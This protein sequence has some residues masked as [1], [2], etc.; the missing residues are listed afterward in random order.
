M[1]EHCRFVAHVEDSA[2]SCAWSLQ[3]IVKAITVTLHKNDCGSHILFVN[4]LE[5]YSILYGLRSKQ[6]TS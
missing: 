1:S 2:Y 4:I 6:M 3:I 5:T